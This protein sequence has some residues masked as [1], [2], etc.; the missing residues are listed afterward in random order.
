M[1]PLRGRDRIVTDRGRPGPLT[2]LFDP[3]EGLVL[4]P[5][6]ELGLTLGIEEGCSHHLDGIGTGEPAHPDGLFGNQLRQARTAA[7]LS[8]Q[9]AADALGTWPIRISRLERALD[10]NRDLADRYQTWLRALEA[11]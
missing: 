6:Q 9:T 8:L 2:A 5:V 4:C 11:A 3:V 7:H 1:G 10:Y